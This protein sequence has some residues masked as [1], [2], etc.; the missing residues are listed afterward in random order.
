[1]VPILTTPYGQLFEH[2]CLD[3]CRALEP[4]SVDLAFADPP[5]NLGKQYS[6][7]IDDSMAV[8]DYLSW[9]R[10]WLDELV[11]V[12]KPGGSLFVWNLPKWSLPLARRRALSL[13]RVLE[14]L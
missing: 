6:S 1:M 11:R 2:D 4:D 12:L 8:E 5:F 13:Q 9:C 7:N 3:V 14:R 10:M